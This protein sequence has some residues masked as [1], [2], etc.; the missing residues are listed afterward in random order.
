MST[1]TFTIAGQLVD[2]VTGTPIVSSSVVIETEARGQYIIDEGNSIL[3]QPVRAVTDALGQFEARLISYPGLR[4]RVRRDPLTS[5]DDAQR[6]E[7]FPPGVR[8]QFDNLF[9]PGAS[10]PSTVPEPVWPVSQHVTYDELTKALEQIKPPDLS[11]YVKITDLPDLS[12]GG[13][14]VVRRQVYDQPTPLATWTIS[15][16]FGRRPNVVV[17][18][19]NSDVLADVEATNDTVTITHAIPLSGQAVLT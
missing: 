3:V 13:G 18:V 4:Y 9:K 19:G 2:R 5:P 16:T 11:Q 10:Q 15:H 12:S 7:S 14:G 6:F 17:Y 8:V 1:S